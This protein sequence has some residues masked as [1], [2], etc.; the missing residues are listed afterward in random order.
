MK[1]K[2]VP[3][4]CGHVFEATIKRKELPIARE[5]NFLG[6]VLFIGGIKMDKTYTMFGCDLCVKCER[7]RYFGGNSSETVI[8][9][10]R[11]MDFYYTFNTFFGDAF[12]FFYDMYNKSKAVRRGR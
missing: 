3:T 12:S 2:V 8:G 9:L 1:I 11:F 6:K 5:I 10:Q 7:E 4:E